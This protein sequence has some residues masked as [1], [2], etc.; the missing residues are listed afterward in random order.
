[1]IESLLRLAC[2]YKTS[3]LT[4]LKFFYKSQVFKTFLRNLRVVHP[5]NLTGLEFFAFYYFLEIS[6]GHMGK[7]LGGGKPF[8]LIRSYICP[9]VEQI[10]C[11]QKNWG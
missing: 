4:F 10:Y 1:M 3:G 7:Y 8:D 11:P 2:V 9:F 5:R 6:G